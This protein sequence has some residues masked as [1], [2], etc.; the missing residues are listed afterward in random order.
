MNGI[1]LNT[2]VSSLVFHQDQQHDKRKVKITYDY[3]RLPCIIYHTTMIDPTLVVVVSTVPVFVS[4][5]K[6]NAKPYT[7]NMQ[8]VHQEPYTIF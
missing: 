1:R 5:F 4:N 6:N 8:I 3:L 7:H 2:T